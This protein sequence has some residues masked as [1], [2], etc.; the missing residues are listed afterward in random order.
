MSYKVYPVTQTELNYNGYEVK[1]NGE[2]VTLDSA[3]VSAMPFN[4]RWPGHQRQLDQTELVNFLSL[5]TG[6]ALHFEITPCEKFEK[7][8]IRPLSLGIVPEITEDGRILFTLEKPAYFTVEPY[9]RHNALHIFADPVSNYDVDKSDENVIYFGKGEHD[10][11]MISYPPQYAL[12][13]A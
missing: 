1:I 11:G 5:E 12:G 3:R 8:V 10:A 13:Q 4:R 9:G 2:K 6:E 7:V